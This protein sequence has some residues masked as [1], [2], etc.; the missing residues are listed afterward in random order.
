MHAFWPL[1]KRELSRM[2]HSSVVMIIVILFLVMLGGMFFRDYFDTV[3]SLSLR[4]FFSQAPT[5]LAFFCPA[6]TMGRI[7]GE[8]SDHTLD[9][10][11]TMPLHSA[12]IVLAKFV[13]CL[14]V[15]VFVLLCT[16]SYPLTLSGLGELDWGPVIGGYVA[17]FMLGGGYCAI[18]LLTSAW[19]ED[20]MI[21]VLT[22]FFL[23]VALTYVD[24]LVVS[25]SGTLAVLLQNLS[26][27][28]HFSNIARGVMDIRDILYTLSLQCIAVCGAVFTLEARRYPDPV[29]KS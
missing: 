2:L 29:V 23:C 14:V 25:S 7:A 1:L 9:L 17:L 13:A 3:R 4:P 28:Y 22:A 16:L 6:L 21:A 19:A 20:Q 18:G 8:R 26:A 15:L 11:L 5:L 24:M 27:S 12:H 10:L